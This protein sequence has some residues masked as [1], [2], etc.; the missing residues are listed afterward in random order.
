MD[1]WLLDLAGKAPRPLTHL[2]YRGAIQAF[3]IT[4]DG[5]HIV[6]DRSQENSS[7]VLIDLPS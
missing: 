7:I 5:T 3:D 6:F 4:P 2:G 1:F